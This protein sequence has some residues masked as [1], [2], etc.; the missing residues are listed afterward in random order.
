MISDIR[1]RFRDRINSQPL[2]PDNR[3]DADNFYAEKQ[4]PDS[5]ED[6]VEPQECSD[7]EVVEQQEGL[8]SKNS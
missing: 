8:E 4:P 5:D 1:K 2:V 3:N 7:G 6:V